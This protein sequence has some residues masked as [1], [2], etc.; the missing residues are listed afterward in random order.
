MTNGEFAEIKQRY[1]SLVGEV[2]SGI[3]KRI[4]LAELTQ[5]KEA[6]YAIEALR[7]TLIHDNDLD[8]KV[9]QLVHFGQL[10]A[11]GRYGPARLHAQGAK[12][13]GASLNE[14]LGVVETSLITSGMPSYAAGVDILHEIFVVNNID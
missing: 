5:R 1:I 6:V 11:L 13:A 2:P 10:L 8:P 14:L 4:D 12:T 9:Q 3:Q 7:K